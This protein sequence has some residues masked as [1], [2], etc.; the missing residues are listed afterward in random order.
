MD[1]LNWRGCESPVP[2][3]GQVA[4]ITGAAKGIGRALA[5]RYAQAGAD[6]VI[7]DIDSAGLP[8]T[9]AMIEGIGRQAR[10][11]VADV[12]LEHDIDA[13]V[14]LA[15]ASFDRVDIVANNAGINAPGGFLGV[16]RQDIRSVFDTDLIGPFFLSQRCAREMIPRKIEG[17]FVCISSIHSVVPAY[18]PHYSAAKIGL[19][20]LV[21]DMALE[22]APYGIRANCIRPGGI[23]IRGR[24]EVGSPDVSN[25]HIPFEG[26]SGLP[27]EVAELAL[28]L[29]TDASRYITGTTVTIDG[30]L[31]RMTYSALARRNTLA[32]EQ[33]QLGFAPIIPEPILK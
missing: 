22:L 18:C 2:L 3:L 29:S 28:F 16:S 12:R 19:E 20:Q 33:D 13:I 15:L 32:R 8:V 17:R 23:A 25:P 21:I 5:I 24:T 31:S 6:V 14:D 1:P 27:S 10:Q 30:A 11:I 26:R 4:I 9:A 7:A